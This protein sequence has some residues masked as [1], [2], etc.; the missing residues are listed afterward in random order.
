MAIESI[1][2]QLLNFNIL[3]WFTFTGAIFSTILMILKIMEHFNKKVMLKIDIKEAYYY[4][5]PFEDETISTTYLELY[6]DLKNIGLEAFT[7]SEIEFASL[8]KKIGSIELDNQKGNPDG[9]KRLTAFYDIRMDK[10][11][12]SIYE[13]F[14][15]VD[16]LGKNN[17]LIK[18][19]LIFKT[20]KKD[21]TKKVTL[22][23]KSLDYKSKYAPKN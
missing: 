8:N 3:E 23:K 6:I 12:R 10:N 22:L 7:I 9:V 15:Y 5:I 14:K 18:G 2:I 16:Y 19:E 17:K 13:L 21:F 4:D 1:W 11:H 20:S